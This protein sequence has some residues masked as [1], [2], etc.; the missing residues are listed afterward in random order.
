MARILRAPDSS[1]ML[2]IGRTCRHPT[3]ACAYQVPSVPCL[4]N[5]RVRRSVNSARSCSGTAQSSMK[6]TGFP[7]PFIDIM[8]FNPAL[9]TAVMSACDCGSMVRTTEPGWPW[10]AS[11]SSRRPSDSMSG[12]CS[13]PANSTRSSASGAPFTWRSN[14]ARKTGSC[15]ARSSMVR[16]TSSTAEGPSSTMNRVTSIASWKRAKWQIAPTLC[17]GTRCSLSLIR[18]KKPSVPSEPTISL[19]RF[20]RGSPRVSRL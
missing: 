13:S 9:R 7:S 19:A 15:R 16:S 10:S 20:W 17:F 1:F 11:V 14:V 5:S 18:V 2:R 12:A 6:E 4:W 8:M 3:E